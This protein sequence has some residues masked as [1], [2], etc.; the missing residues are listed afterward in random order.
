MVSRGRRRRTMMMRR[1]G[2]TM[3]RAW[4]VW[5][6]L[7][8]HPRTHLLALLLFGTLRFTLCGLD[9][10]QITLVHETLL[11]VVKN[12][13]LIV[14]HRERPYKHFICDV[15]ASDALH[16]SHSSYAIHIR[17][18]SIPSFFPLVIRTRALT[19]STP[20]QSQAHS[21]TY[22]I[23][24]AWM[25]THPRQVL[26]DMT[27]VLS[28]NR[29]TEQL[30]TSWYSTYCWLFPDLL[31]SLYPMPRSKPRPKSSMGISL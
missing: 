16:N 21:S 12:N 3:M 1:G 9:E 25:Y 10:L 11:L 17:N 5:L 6:G 22:W 24:S 8:A 29:I 27:T 2:R 31:L 26:I 20:T 30:H 14:A 4:R 7:I 15:T 13:L 19:E 28:T 18:G 23:G